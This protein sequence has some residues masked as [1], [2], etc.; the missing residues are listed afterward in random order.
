MKR[1]LAIIMSI[2]ML[3]VLIGCDG[4]DASAGTNND[5][6]A[7]N[8]NNEC[9]H[10]YSDATCTTPKTCTICGDTTGSTNSHTFGEYSVVKNPSCKEKGLKERSCSACGEKETVYLDMTDHT[11]KDATCAAPKTCS[12]CGTSDGNALPHT[13][14]P[15]KDWN[16]TDCGQRIYANNY[17]YMVGNDFGRI[18]SNYSHAVANYAYVTAYEDDVGE[19]CVLVDIHYS[20]GSAKFEDVVLHNIS[21]GTEIKDPIN[22]YDEQKDRAYGATK[23]RYMQIKTKILKALSTIDEHGHRVDGDYLNTYW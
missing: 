11:W 1:I 13:A 8:G 12:V 2:C 23:L 9:E 16:C 18:K 14:I 22:Y 5:A 19:F 7:E 10:N 3:F 6:V 4:A 17:V 20:I 21:N 15:D